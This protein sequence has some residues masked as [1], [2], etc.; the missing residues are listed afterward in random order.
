MWY[1]VAIVGIAFVL[2][3]PRYFASENPQYDFVY[4]WVEGGSGNVPHKSNSPFRLEGG[5]LIVVPTAT[6]SITSGNGRIHIYLHHVSANR[7][8]PI[9]QEDIDHYRLV[10]GTIA[11]DGF[12]FTK[13]DPNIFDRSIKTRYA[14][15]K[16]IN[17]VNIP[18]SIPNDG[19][20]EPLFIG[21][22]N[23]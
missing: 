13:V 15:V 22:V 1:A 20:T 2:F 17:Q 12:V 6:S 3:A 5:K 14:L 21:W 7:S 19:L 23:R 11:P 16:G 9:T 10:E 4:A 18:L 8:V